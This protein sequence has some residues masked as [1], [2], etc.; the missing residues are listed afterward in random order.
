MAHHVPPRHRIDAFLRLDGDGTHEAIGDYLATPAR[1]TWTPL[2]SRT[3]HI[4]RMIISVQDAGAFDAAKYGNA[5]VLANGIS[6]TV[7]NVADDA[8]V[9]TYTVEPIITN[10]DWAAHCYDTDMK[11]WGTGDEILVARWTFTR[12]GSPMILKDTEYVSIDVNDTLTGLKA[13]RF[14]IQ[15]EYV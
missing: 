10:S 8:Q 7:R 4:H 12:A 2:P 5:I 15:G 1:F 14:V 6:L 3:A 11:T 13:H 9:H